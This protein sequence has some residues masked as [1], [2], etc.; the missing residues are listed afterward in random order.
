MCGVRQRSDFTEGFISGLSILFH[1]LCRRP[2]YPWALWIRRC[3]R[4][5]S[6]GYA[7]RV[8]PWSG[9]SADTEHGPDRCC[10]HVTCLSLMWD[11]QLFFPE[12]VVGVPGLWIPTCVLRLAC[13]ILW[14][15]RGFA[16]SRSICRSSVGTARVTVV[17]SADPRRWNIFPL[18]YLGVSFLSVVL[19]FSV[20]K[21][22]FR[23]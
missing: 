18:V 23:F 22:L 9:D 3:S 1:W 13:Q 16:G 15:S 20:P 12:T 17:K 6:A 19:Q 10:S 2:W 14:K 7:S 21:A 5:R 4:P 8:C 11:L